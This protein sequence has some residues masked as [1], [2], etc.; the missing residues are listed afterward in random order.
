MSLYTTDQPTIHVLNGK[1]TG[2]FRFQNF[3][4]NFFLTLSKEYWTG[5]MLFSAAFSSKVYASGPRYWLQE[6][7]PGP[8]HVVLL[9]RTAYS[10]HQDIPSTQSRA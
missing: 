1:F 2:S 7:G 10:L 5:R 4:W 3:C 6:A 8:R 9:S